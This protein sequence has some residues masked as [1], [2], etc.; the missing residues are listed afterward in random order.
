MSDGSATRMR[1]MYRKLC[2][3]AVIIRRYTG[4]GD[5]RS[6]KDY[7]VRGNARL[8]AT[9]ELAEGILQGDVKAI[10][11]VEDLTAQGF[12]LPL[13]TSTDRVVYNGRERAILVPGD[14]AALDSTLIAYEIQARG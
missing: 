14:R 3:H 12:V 11:L 10:A 13:S 7:T 1:A 9:S 4:S 8:Y 6:K 5:A 2:K